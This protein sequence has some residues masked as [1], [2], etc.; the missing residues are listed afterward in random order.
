[1]C[2]E[3]GYIQNAKFSVLVLDAIKKLNLLIRPDILNIVEAA[4][5]H[6]EWLNSAIGNKYGDIYER[7]LELAMNSRMNKTKDGD[8]ISDGFLEYIVPMLKGKM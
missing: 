5:I 2:Y 3:S 6:D 1:M 8:A 4:G 7:H